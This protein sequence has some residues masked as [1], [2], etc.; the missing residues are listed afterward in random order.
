MWRKKSDQY[1]TDFVWDV[2]EL[3]PEQRAFRFGFLWSRKE[4]ARN[5]TIVA[6]IRHTEWGG[7]ILDVGCG[8]GVLKCYLGDDYPGCYVGIDSSEYAIGNAVV[9]DV[10]D[11]TFLN[12]AAEDFQSDEKFKFIVF[13]ECLYYMD[14]P[15]LV[16][17]R[18]TKNL[19]EN[20]N[21]IVSIF[22]LP[23]S[24]KLLRNLNARFECIHKVEILTH[25]QTIPAGRKLEKGASSLRRLRYVVG[26]ARFMLRR[27]LPGITIL[28]LRP[29]G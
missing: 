12:V 14:K 2:P 28:V 24:K 3:T 10:P 26:S 25:L 29:K 1:S 22:P 19:L 13:N 9:R 4:V 11:V 6:L 18:L 16:V 5:G 20:G 7:S 17:E 15:L 21:F 27:L 8:E 23:G